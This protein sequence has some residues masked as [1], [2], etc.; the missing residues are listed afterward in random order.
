MPKSGRKALIF[1]AQGV[2]EAADMARKPRV[3]AIPWGETSGDVIAPGWVVGPAG[4]EPAT[5]P[6]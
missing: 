5:T 3:S 6:L 1:F 2:S 4:L